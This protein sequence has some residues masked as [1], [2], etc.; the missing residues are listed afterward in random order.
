MM[1]PLSHRKGLST[2]GLLRSTDGMVKFTADELVIWMLSGPHGSWLP[3]DWHSY[4]F[5]R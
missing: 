4:C 2:C 5:P 1:R 3:K